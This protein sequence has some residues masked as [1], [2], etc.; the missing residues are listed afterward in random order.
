MQQERTA[1]EARLRARECAALLERVDS[2]PSRRFYQH[3][4]ES[5]VRTANLLEIIEAAHANE[6][7]RLNWV[8]ERG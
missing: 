7:M 5:W 3:L 1:D 4:Y 2:A 8:G 6:A